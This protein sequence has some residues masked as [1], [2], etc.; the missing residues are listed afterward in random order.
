MLKHRGE[1]Q[2]PPKSISFQA[3]LR[4]YKSQAALGER[5]PFS[6]IPYKPKKELISI[7]YIYIYIM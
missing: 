2:L 1:Q 4:S 3:G 5:R 7:L 6:T